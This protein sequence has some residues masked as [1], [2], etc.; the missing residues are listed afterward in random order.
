[1]SQQSPTG[2]PTVIRRAL[3]AAL[4][5][6]GLVPAL[7]ASSASPAAAAGSVTL[8][9]STGLNPAGETI[10]VSG[11]G[12]DS[13][14][15]RG[16][17]LLFCKQTPSRPSG[18][19]CS[20]AQ[21]WISHPGTP[22]PVKWSG[23]GT[24]TATID[25]VG[26]WEG[27][28]CYQVVCGVVTRNDHSDGHLFDQDSF[29]P[30]SFAVEETTTTTEAQAS[31]TTT[32]KPNTVGPKVELS[33]SS[34]L[35]DGEVITVSG[36]GFTPNQGLYVQI[37]EESGGVVGTAAGR[38]TNCYP[39]QDGTHTVWLNPV[40]ATGTWSTPLTVTDSFGD[41][42]CRNT[43]CGVFVR[44]DHSGGATDFSQDVF[45]A[46]TFGDSTTT[47]TVPSTGA[48]LTVT[49]ATGLTSGQTVSVEGEGFAP[50]QNLFVGVCDLAVSNFAAC[51]FANVAEVT[52]ASTARVGGPGTFSAS[53]V[54]RSVFAATDCSRSTSRCAVATWAV[55][56]SDATAEVST[57][58]SFRSTSATPA[59]NGTVGGRPLPRTG[60][61]TTPWV[62]AGTGALIAGFAALAL[63]RRRRMA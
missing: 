63:E 16:I 53:L 35:G 52:T 3:A 43:V 24:F 31:T 42:D 59:P 13:S 61:A 58:I 36:T 8:S 11:S 23:N 18:G 15:T 17:Y 5:V 12:F 26:A 55:S 37:C 10:T 51:D 1:M 34:D 41:V 62:L 45:T 46:I 57:P 14:G 22:A 32:T 54:V 39:E 20:G 6:A 2:R 30:V 40:G 9:K 49:P 50:G 25:V 33:K 21:N 38:S 47:P 27:V 4:L 56:G 48:R 7:I 19:E 60:T 44:R 29:T 28:N